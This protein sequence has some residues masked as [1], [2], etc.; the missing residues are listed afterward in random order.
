MRQR[1]DILALCIAASGA[2]HLA[3]A[4]L[5]EPP[6]T[7]APGGDIAGEVA[8]GT[9]FASLS[10][11]TLS[12]Q[13]TASQLEA[14]QPDIQRPVEHAIQ[15]LRTNAPTAVTKPATEMAKSTLATAL[16]S[17]RVQTVVKAQKP[18]QTVKAKAPTK[19]AK[20]KPK[21]KPAKGNA[22][23]SVA[24][25]KSTGSAT[26]KNAQSNR[27]KATNSRQVGKGAI[28]S[29]KTNVLRRVARASARVRSVGSAGNVRVGL[30]IHGTGSISATK[31]VQS[32]GDRLV[33]RA[34][35]AAV[36]AAGPF[37]KTPHGQPIQLVVRVSVKG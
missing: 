3:F 31:V 35:K 9:S 33:D 13:Q 6:A 11:G 17:S 2:A 8:I 12:G 18:L 23:V 37:G 32:S 27:A 14:V 21:A 10:S 29:Y 20:P 36:Q 4:G 16:N 30:A 1:F 25:G 26:G 22:K 24:A 19:T 7:Q 5:G 34:A 15:P 28:N